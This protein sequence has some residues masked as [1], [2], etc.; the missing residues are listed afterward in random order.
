MACERLWR[1]A[2]KIIAFQTSH[3]PVWTMVM[4][5][6]RPRSQAHGGPLAPPHGEVTEA[7]RAGMICLK[8]HSDPGFEQSCPPRYLPQV[9]HRIS[10]VL[11]QETGGL[12]L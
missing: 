4:L 3:T 8:T 9:R 10:L 11:Y 2:N 5:L 7:Q 1:E 6:N 12:E